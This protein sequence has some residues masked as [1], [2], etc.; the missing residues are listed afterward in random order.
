MKYNH[1]FGP[2]PS[3][4]LGISLGIDLVT[5]KICSM[6]CIYCECGKTT[7]LTLERR[8]YVRFED[9]KNELDHYWNHNVD[10]NYITFSGSG[11]PTLNSRIGEVIE[12]IKEKK[13]DI[14]VAV[15]TNSSLFS[16]PAV[17]KAL[18]KADLVVPSL[19]AAS[20]K[21]FARIN[22]SNKGLEVNKLVKGIETFAK[23]YQ[24]RLWLEVFILPKINDGKSDLLKLKDAIKKINPDLV[25][26]NTLDRPGTLLDIKPASRSELE[27]V[28][29]TIGF[30]NIEIIANVDSQIKAGI[31]RKDVK[32][33]IIETIHRRPC[34]KK[35][36]LQILGVEKKVIDNNINLLEKEK[37]IIGK[38]RERG[39]F[40]QTLKEQ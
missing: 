37:K 6:D 28:V 13:P 7:Q 18:L 3:R 4:R 35:D 31:Q 5:H 19:D 1:I 24:G 33:A 20:K 14:K 36:L 17:R 29:H 38:T 39:V 23:E 16:D 11:E 30:H 9:V 34:T 10:P 32:A 27:K 25:Q 2:V 12:Y 15:L 8:E 21:G 26:I 40:Y 22:R